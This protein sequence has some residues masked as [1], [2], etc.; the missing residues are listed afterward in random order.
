MVP[1]P[2][3][4]GQSCSPAPELLAYL[5]ANPGVDVLAIV[6]VEVHEGAC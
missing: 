1:H 6:W 4:G 2:G 5:L 3:A